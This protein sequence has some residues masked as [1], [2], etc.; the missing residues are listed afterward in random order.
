MPVGHVNPDTREFTLG[1]LRSGKYVVRLTLPNGWMVKS[2][3]CAFRD[4]SEGLIDTANGLDAGP[5]V[6]TVTDQLT[7][8]SGH[9]SDSQGKVVDDCVVWAFPLQPSLWTG[10][11][12]TP[13]RIRQSRASGQAGYSIRG[14]PAGEYFLVALPSANLQ[15]W[16]N[17]AILATAA[18]LSTSIRLGWGES[19]TRD[20]TLREIK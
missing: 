6:I 8:V 3:K 4:C 7:G 15:A 20:L 11:G 13:L 19:Q 18:R 17:P 2:T 5:L 10:Y 9:V 1:G 12:L 16:T 14:L